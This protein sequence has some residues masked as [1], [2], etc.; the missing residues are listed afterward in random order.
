MET[1][2]S[3]GFPICTAV[4]RQAASLWNDKT[5]HL[6]EAL[7]D[8]HRKQLLANAWMEQYL[9]T[10]SSSGAVGGASTTEAETHFIT[11]FLNSAVRAQFVCSDPTNSQP[12]IRDMVLDQLAEGRIF[13]LDLAAGSGAGTLAIL[14]TICELRNTE[15]VPTL[16]LNVH[17]FGIDYSSRALALYQGDCT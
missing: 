1:F 13:I 12:D 11:R 16:P 3:A 17:I 9:A 2:V 14:S 7:V 15:C 4:V 8:A 6:P 5:L 10:S